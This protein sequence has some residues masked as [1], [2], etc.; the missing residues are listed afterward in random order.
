MGK[1]PID[2]TVK[3]LR[4]EHYNEEFERS[5]NDAFCVSRK[6][7]ILNI[8]ILIL[9]GCLYSTA[10]PPYNFSFIAWIAVVPLIIVI[11][12]RTPLMAALSGAIW[13]YAWGVTSFYWLREIE[14]PIPFAM[15]GILAAFHAVWALLVPIFY[16]SILHIDSKSE[17]T[18]RYWLKEIF[19]VL[20]LSC[21]W[22]ILEWVR[23][24]IFTG[25]PWNF[26]GVT[27]WKNIPII[28]IAEFTG[29]YGVSFILIY[30]NCA[31]FL[32]VG[33]IRKSIAT[34][35]HCRPV[36]LFSAA[37]LLL[38]SVLAGAKSLLHYSSTKTNKTDS[39]S[40]AL[41]QANIP[42]CRF[43][44]PGIAEYALDEH[45]KLSR[46]VAVLQ[47]DL[48]AWPE[49]AVPVPYI[50]GDNLGYLYRFKVNN[51][52][53]ETNIPLMFGTLDFEQ[54]ITTQGKEPDYDE[55]NAVYL[56]NT[57]DE[58][59]DKYRK[60]HLVPFGEYTPFGKYYPDLKEKLGMGRDL[61]PG[62]KYTIFELKN[63]IKAGALIC[64][65]DIFPNIS[66]ELVL[67]GA[68][69]L[70][71]FSNDA[72]Y[73]TSSEPEQHLAN[74]IFRA[75]E[76]RRPLVRVGNNSCSCLI[77]PNGNIVDSVSVDEEDGK[78][79]LKPEKSV[80][81]FAKFD[82][83]VIKSGPNTFYTRYGNVFIYICFVLFI[84]AIIV[85]AA[86]Y[87]NNKLSLLK[88]FE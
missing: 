79:V 51:L 7:K 55:Y 50:S 78:I 52:I 25:F 88:S 72:W 80:K 22:S 36:P 26:A 46:M 85:S 66:R 33:V 20:A 70:I 11:Y 60:H 58:I 69:M 35:K 67:R 31:I 63:K 3:E 73:P 53:K 47:P 34:G 16:K 30:V 23:A 38:L 12:K 43:P 49:T 10:F 5:G 8:L 1:N 17:K 48:I 45:I 82:I 2:K 19:F 62:K 21:W 61:T 18:K 86:H 9:S 75:I 37:A 76:T 28:Q 77:L 24:W 84:F 83:S 59:V 57:S 64:F 56:V 40:I 39:I 81:A 44:K 29:V 65:E 41:I 13:G 14:S 71:V 87:K 15:G 54:K 42:Q 32:A 74:S 6:W 4:E 27:Q 68:D